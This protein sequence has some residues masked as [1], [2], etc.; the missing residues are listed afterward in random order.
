MTRQYC[1]FVVW[2]FSCFVVCRVRL[3]FDYQQNNKTTKPQNDQT[4]LWFCGF[5]VLLFCRL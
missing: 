5:V 2:L 3:E 4:I 1:G